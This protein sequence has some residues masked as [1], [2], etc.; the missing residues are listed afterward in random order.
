MSSYCLVFSM[1]LLICRPALGFSS[2]WSILKVQVLNNFA[3]L[4]LPVSNVAFVVLC[5]KA[6]RE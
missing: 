5:C 2:V 6:G 4:F 3:V 1:P